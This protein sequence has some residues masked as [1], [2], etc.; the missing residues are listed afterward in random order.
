[1]NINKFGQELI[2]AGLGNLPISFGADGIIEYGEGITAAER[3]AVE[4]F[5]AAYV[6]GP[7]VPAEVPALSGLLALSEAGFSA[8][9]EAWATD[10][11]RTFDERAFINRSQSWRRDNAVLSSAAAALGISDVQLDQLFILASTK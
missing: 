10:P 1:M 8:A 11:A 4:Q 9:F 2:A 3:T 5:A 6:D 7:E